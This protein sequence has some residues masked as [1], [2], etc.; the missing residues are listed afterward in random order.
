MQIAIQEDMLTG[1]TVLQKFENAQR[2]GI[3][4]IEF[5]ADGLADRVPQI[6]QAIA[7]TGVQAAAVNFGRLGTLL[8]ADPEQ[9]QRV[10]VQMRL[11]MAS[12]IDIGASRMVFVPQFGAPLLPN[13][14]PYKSE[15]QLEADMLVAYLKQIFTD[16]AYAMGMTLYLLPV[17][18]Y[19]SHFV[20]RLEQGASIRRK[21]KNHAH[22]LLAA[23]LF[24][25]L[26]EEE[27]WPQALRTYAGE[28][29]YMQIA[30]SNRRLPGQGL[31]DFAAFAAL[32]RQIGYDGWLTLE[33][34]LPGQNQEDAPR[35]MRELPASLHVLQ[36]ALSQ[37]SR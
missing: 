4:G 19:E 13:L 11:S 37:A 34:G 17:N 27:D 29:G 12:A 2:L 15:I 22:I 33:C 35:F 23:N 14:L 10:V 31:L 16:L 25:M 24:H 7:Q 36:Q 21:I 5:W 32:L 18:R 20:N 30:D 6:A 9:R 8:T 26:L 1:R 3:A 28:I